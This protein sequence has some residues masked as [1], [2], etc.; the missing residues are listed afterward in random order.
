MHSPETYQRLIESHKAAI[1]S[2]KDKSADEQIKARVTDREAAIKR[3]EAAKA[4]AVQ[5]QQA[6]PKEQPDAQ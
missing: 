4:K 3:L 6:K 2:V 1:N 5:E